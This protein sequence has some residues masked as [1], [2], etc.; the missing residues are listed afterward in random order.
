VLV[1]SLIRREEAVDRA[2]REALAEAVGLEAFSPN[3]WSGEDSALRQVR[4]ARTGTRTR[5]EGHTWTLW[6]IE[7]MAVVPGTMRKPTLLVRDGNWACWDEPVHDELRKRG[8]LSKRGEASWLA[9][10]FTGSQATRDAPTTGEDD[11]DLRS[12]TLPWPAEQVESALL[13]D[14]G[15]L[16]AELVPGEPLGHPPNTVLVRSHHIENWSIEALQSA[17]R[18][19]QRAF[20]WSPSHPDKAAAIVPPAYRWGSCMLVGGIAGLVIALLGLATTLEGAS[21]VTST[22]IL[23]L[24][25]LYLGVGL[26]GTFVAIVWAIRKH[27]QH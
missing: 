6:A 24:L 25:G 20:G 15:F 10:E 1:V 18:A 22:R 12:L 27:K 23:L 13:A 2:Q 7:L 16:K 17:V 3:Y 26:A 8:R 4:R 9:L 19:S 11:P 5:S 14:P 21:P